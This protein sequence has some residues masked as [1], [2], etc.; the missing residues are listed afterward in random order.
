MNGPK[1]AGR[2]GGLALFDRFLLGM[3]TSFLALRYK[4]LR[5]AFVLHAV[6]NGVAA[7]A[8]ALWR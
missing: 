8:I 6:N 4:S 7:L 3:A 1:K 2:S 5:P